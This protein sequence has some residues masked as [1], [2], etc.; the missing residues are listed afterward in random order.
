MA[1]II[2]DGNTRVAWVT[3]I[4]NTSAPTAAELN[5]GI[6]LQSTMTPDGLSGF[7]P[8]TAD[9]PN[10]KLDST[11]NTVDTG[12]V[13]FSNVELRFYKQS[14]TDTIYN[15]LI[16]GTAGYV[17]VRRSAPAGG[18]FATSDKV[19][20]YPAKCGETSWMDPEQDTEER[21]AIPIKIT[22]QPVIRAVVA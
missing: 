6:V 13:S 5:A 22:S 18:V 8:T 20:I 1:D 16:R 17:A 15:T 19:Q 10:R 21:Y 11:F 12:T 7:Q 2:S 9:V 14:G 4:S 3:S